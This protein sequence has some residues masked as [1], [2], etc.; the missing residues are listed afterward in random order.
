MIKRYKHISFDLDGTLVYTLPEYRNKV[1]SG[2]VKELG[3]KVKSD[4]SVNRFWFE[5]GRNR[6]IKNE[7]NLD[8]SVFWPV[9]RRND[10]AEERSRFT[11]AYQ[12]VESGFKKLKKHNK[13]ISIIT[14]A[15]DRVADFEIKKLNGVPY[16][17][18]LSIF[19]KGYKEKPDP[20]SFHFVLEKMKIKPRETL[21][22]GNS[23]E[24]ALYAKN[25]GADFVH[26]ERGEHILD[27]KEHSLAVINS[28]DELFHA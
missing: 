14:G 26:L 6:I 19:D 5:T 17:F 7:F 21:Y 15:P 18:Y 23:N 13:F 11:N 25:T 16:D 24:D 12:D 22:I 28:L 3:G 2:T 20:E 9:F 1:V 4:N 10:K 8:P 27:L